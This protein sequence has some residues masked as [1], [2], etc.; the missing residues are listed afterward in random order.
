MKHL[1]FSLLLCLPLSAASLDI[2]DGHIHYNDDVWADLAPEHAMEL[3][4][5]N[6]INRAIVFSTPAEGTKKLYR[7]APDRIIPFIRPYRVFR[8]RFSW[9]SDE[10]MLA[11]VTQEV[12]TGFYQG[13]GEF[14]LFKKHKNTPVVQKFMQLMAKHRLAVSAH[15]DG[16]TIEA[17]INMQPQVTMIWAH[18]GMDHPVEDVQRMLEQYPSLYCEL[19]F[20]DQLTDEHN[21]LTPKWKALLEKHPERFMTGMDTYIPRR[22]AHL[23]EIKEYA[24]TWLSQLDNKAAALIAGG[25]I[26]RLFPLE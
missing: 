26:E 9:H 21:V 6:S 25:N 19:S 5:D 23:P 7:L 18:C 2:H 8:D 22:W 24:E 13:F 17:L 3:L 1:F 11:Y 12:E 15:S 16:E 20:R 10:K 14:H 4:N